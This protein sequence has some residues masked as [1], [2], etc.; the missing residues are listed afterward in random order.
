[1]PRK[2]NQTTAVLFTND[3]K[4]V[5]RPSSSF[6]T[7]K[8]LL[9]TNDTALVI[10][11]AMQFL[12]LV[13][14]IDEPVVCFAEIG[15]EDGI[16]QEGG[17]VF[18]SWKYALDCVFSGKSIIT[19]TED[20][21]GNFFISTVTPAGIESHFSF[22]TLT[23]AGMTFYKRRPHEKRQTLVTALISAPYSRCCRVSE[24]LQ[25]AS[26]SGTRIAQAA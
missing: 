10:S 4:A 16:V 6:L 21:W 19:A 22:K 8:D 11:N 2:L 9:F 12:S 3:P 24:K 5:S 18:M 7:D 13:A 20:I 25:A 23:P 14:Q 17:A 26:Q 15:M 1:M